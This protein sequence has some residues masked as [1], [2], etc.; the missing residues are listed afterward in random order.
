M[1]ESARYDE[2]G[3][4][5]VVF[6]G[7]TYTVP[8]DMSNRYRRMLDDEGVAIQQYVA[9]PPP[10]AVEIEGEVQKVADD[11][12]QNSERDMAVA[13]ATVDLVR[14]AVAGQLT[15]LTLAQTRAA[16]RDRIVEYVRQSR[17]QG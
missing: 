15:N 16:Y 7:R 3:N 17:S 8:D 9:P 5:T 13:L 6:S 10:S 4:I 12:L 11:I 1:I 14:A 2:F